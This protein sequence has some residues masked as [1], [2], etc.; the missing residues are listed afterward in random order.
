V[1]LTISESENYL[2]LP[3]YNFFVIFELLFIAVFIYFLLIKNTLI[4]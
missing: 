3:E 4:E 2:S 1:V